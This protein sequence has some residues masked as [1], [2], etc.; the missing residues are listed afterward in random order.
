MWHFKA[1][2]DILSLRLLF[3]WWSL[4]KILW[5]GDDKGNIDKW[6]D[7]G[8]F[9][10]RIWFYVLLRGDILVHWPGR[11]N[12]IRR[13]KTIVR[14]S[15]SFGSLL[16]M[17]RGKWCKILGAFEYMGRGLGWGRSF[18]NVTRCWRLSYRINWG[19]S[20][21]NYKLLK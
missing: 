19:S 3:H 6:S 7:C 4:W 5:K 12:S 8:Q 21:P 16:W 11:L 1:E 13:A 9:W 17:G 15:R 10:A 14:E 18:S 20:D 2:E